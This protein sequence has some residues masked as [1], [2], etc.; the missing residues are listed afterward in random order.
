MKNLI[1]N[2]NYLFFVEKLT[3]LCIEHMFV[4]IIYIRCVIESNNVLFFFEFDQ[5]DYITKHN[6]FVENDH[7]HYN[8]D[9][10]MYKL[11]IK[12]L[13]NFFVCFFECFLRFGKQDTPE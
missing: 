9:D 3:Y 8:D 10:Q 2:K 4:C 12:I 11:F 13:Q 6:G 1:S 7:H 5:F